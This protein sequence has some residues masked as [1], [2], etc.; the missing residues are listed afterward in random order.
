MMLGWFLSRSTMA[1]K[2]FQSNIPW[3]VLAWRLILFLR[4][5]DKGTRRGGG[6]TA[7]KHGC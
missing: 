5:L 3:V 4:F 7:A 2:A 1:W 6:G